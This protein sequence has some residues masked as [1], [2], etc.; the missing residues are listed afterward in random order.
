MCTLLAHL[1]FS[2]ATL[3][4]SVMVILY[5]LDEETEVHSGNAFSLGETGDKQRSWSHGLDQLRDVCCHSSPLLSIGITGRVKMVLMKL[6]A[7][8]G[9]CFCISCRGLVPALV[10]MDPF[11]RKERKK[12]QKNLFPC[13]SAIRSLY[14]PG[15]SRVFLLK[16][17]HRERTLY[18]TT[19]PEAKQ[20]LKT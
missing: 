11:H 17:K 16:G 13:W 9:S 18:K 1:I 7:P 15:M 4:H 10:S 2:P 8:P 12:N 5:F 19:F 3:L 14:D 6:T 20:L